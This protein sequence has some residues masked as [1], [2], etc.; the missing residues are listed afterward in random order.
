VGARQRLFG[1]VD[2]QRLGA[3]EKGC[4]A[5]RPAARFEI[6]VERLYAVA[7]DDAGVGKDAGEALEFGKAGPENIPCRG[8]DTMAALD[9]AALDTAALDIAALGIARTLLPLTS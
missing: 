1:D 5:L 2:E 9:M 6:P 3:F 8:Q 7:L 4:R